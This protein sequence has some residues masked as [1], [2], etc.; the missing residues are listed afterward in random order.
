MLR[1]AAVP[2]ATSSHGSSCRT[3]RSDEWT[4]RVEAW[5]K[6]TCAEQGVPVKLSDPL[7]LAEIAEILL[8][9]R[10]KRSPGGRALA[11]ASVPA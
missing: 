10:D 4:E 5:P 3:G 6:Q 9:G 11:W 1:S 8:S 2:R 7:A